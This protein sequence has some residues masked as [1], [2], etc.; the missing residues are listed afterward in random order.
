MRF[1]I[2]WLLGLALS[3]CIWQMI[4]WQQV[5]KDGF[6][7]VVT[8]TDCSLKHHC[9]FTLTSER[10][11][12]TINCNKLFII[13]MASLFWV[14]RRFPSYKGHKAC[15]AFMYSMCNLNWNEKLVTVRVTRS[16]LF[17]HLCISGA[18]R[19]LCKR[20]WCQRVTTGVML[21]CSSWRVKQ[22]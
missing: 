5:I 11:W 15:S 19:L 16:D 1:Q 4:P 14:L 3:L 6:I 12:I 8:G 2:L 13:G 10:L 7:F 22:R 18:G 20:V 21:A 17:S 9:M